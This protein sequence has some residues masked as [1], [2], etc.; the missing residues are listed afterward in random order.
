MI[1]FRI[2]EGHVVKDIVEAPTGG[3]N[4]VEVAR[5]FHACALATRSGRVPVITR[6]TNV[7]TQTASLC[8]VSIVLLLNSKSQTCLRRR[9][10]SCGL[11]SVELLN[12]SIPFACVNL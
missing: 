4:L 5:A 9:V 12:P 11:P 1:E 7:T 3:D 8:S 2:S 10:R 6:L